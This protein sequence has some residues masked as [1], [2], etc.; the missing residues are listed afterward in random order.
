MKKTL[1]IFFLLTIFQKGVFALYEGNPSS[2]SVIQKSL[3]I[4]DDYWLAIELSYDVNFLFDKSLRPTNRNVQRIDDM[5]YILQ[6]ASLKFVFFD[7]FQFYGGL[8]AQKFKFDVTTE[9]QTS[10]SID[11]SNDLAW[12]IGINALIYNYGS[13]SLGLGFEYETAHPNIQRLR[14]NG[15][16]FASTSGSKIRYQE[17]QFSL[18]LSYTTDLLVPYI[19]YCYSHPIIN[20]KKFSP[21]YLP[22]DKNRFTAKGRKK[23]GGAAGVTIIAKEYFSFNF[24]ARFI[25]ET[26]ITFAGTCRF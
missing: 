21:G 26:A 14:E 12:Q 2:A 4:P 8:G 17:W 13:L 11:T 3:Y 5:Q 25:D 9:P 23:S 19:A 7:R 1:C 6:L 20:F 15:K 22:K 18:G 10:L 16:P 24:E